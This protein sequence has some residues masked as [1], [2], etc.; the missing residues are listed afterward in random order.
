MKS[1][2]QRGKTY[3]TASSKLAKVLWVSDKG[4]AV[5]IAPHTKEEYVDFYDLNG[6]PDS[7]QARLLGS[8]SENYINNLQEEVE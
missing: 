3:R 6:F 4:L 5:V 7:T 8:S 1:K 2:F